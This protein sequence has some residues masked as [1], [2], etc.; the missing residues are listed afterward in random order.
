MK[1]KRIAID[2]SKHVFTL[3]GVDEH[4]RPMLQRNLKRAEMEA[5]FGKLAATEVVMEACGGAHHWARLL[6]QLGHRSRLIPAHYVKPFVK[7][8]KNDRAD[9]AAINDAASR[10]DMPTVPIKSA[11]QQ[12]NSM[13]LK[14]RELLI[15]QRTAAINALRGHAAEFGIIAA[16]GTAQIEALLAKLQDEATVPAVAKAMFV[17]MGEHIAALDQ[18]IEVLEQ[19]LRALHKTDPMSQLLAAVPGIGPITAITLSLSIEPAHFASG[20]HFAAWLG[21]T[22]KEHSTGGKPRLGK[23]SK[24]GNERLRTLL[25]VGA[26]AVIRHAK[27]GRKTSSTWLLQL[28]GRK[29]R[30]LAAVALANK[31]A[32]IV[33]AM[34]ARGEA[35][36]HSPVAA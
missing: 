3:H 27:P 35:Y 5:F 21:L 13:I 4:E 11:D 2:T 31:M 36:R 33:W 9:A 28:L 10:P 1:Y 25:V 7:R 29:P 17:Q 20:R 12:A 19:E 16:K 30:K 34:M 14:H 32:R 6:S 22:P 8:A 23:I 24:A 15:G 18:R 26:M